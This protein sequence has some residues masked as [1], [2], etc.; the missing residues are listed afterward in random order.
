MTRA[1]PRVE[2]VKRRLRIDGLE[3][4]ERIRSVPVFTG[5]TAVEQR[6]DGEHECRESG[7]KEAAL[8][9]STADMSA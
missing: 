4:S 2:T 5:S 6:E 7:Q 3:S 9:G 8:Q 1:F